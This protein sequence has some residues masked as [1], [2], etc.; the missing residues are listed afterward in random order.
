M[1]PNATGGVDSRTEAL[2]RRLVRREADAPLRKLLAKTPPQDIAAAME[3]LTWFEQKRMYRLIEDPDVAAEVLAHLSGTSTRELTREMSEEAVADLLERMEPDDATDIVGVLPHA[4]RDR[5]LDQLEEDDTGAGDEVKALLAYGPQTAGG[6]MSTKAFVLPGTLTCGEAI[7]ALQEQH[8]EL[9]TA[10]YV[11]VIDAARRLVGVTSLRN[12]LTHPARIPIAS[13]MTRDLITVKPGDDQEEVARIVARYDLLAVPVVDDQ[14]HI[15][16]IVTVDDVVDVFREEAAEDM[17]LMAGV[18]EGQP[19]LVRTA[20]YRASWLFA[21]ISGGVVAS[22]LIGLFESTLASKAVLA[23]FVPVIMGMGGNVGI[24]SATLAV[25]GLATGRI[26]VGGRFAFL[27]REARVGLVLGLLFAGMLTV[28]GVV[29]YP[30]E[31]MLGPA[32]GLSIFLAIAAAGLIG[33]GL[34]LGFQRV[35][36]DPAAATTFVTMVQDLLGIVVYFSVA[37]AL[38]PL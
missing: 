20:A 31:P 36:V 33:A 16:G 8:E 22:E 12:L 1:A 24:Q 11:Y 5:V 35:G 14:N 34:P 4:F 25:R 23:G 19:S 37:R 17:M 3:H 9:E 18:S 32:V 13:V 26:S 10:Y 6:I 28:Y 15:L 7:A 30:G 2:L 38:L 21:T 27:W 29:R